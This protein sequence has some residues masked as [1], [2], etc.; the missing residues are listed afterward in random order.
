MHPS[1]YLMR[2]SQRTWAPDGPGVGGSDAGAGAS[3]S[4]GAANNS[5]GNS[6]GQNN[7]AA[8]QDNAGT[9]FDPATF[10]NEP[11][12]AGSGSPSGGSADSN[13]AG[14]SQ[15]Q[16]TEAQ[17]YGQEF[18]QRLSGLDFGSAFTPEIAS[19]VAEGKFEGINKAIGD[20]LKSATQNSVIMAAQ[21][22]Q[23]NNESLLSQVRNLIQESLGNRDNNATLAESF[24]ILAKDP[25]LRPMV[26]GVFNQAL[27]LAN[28]DR[29]KAVASTQE[30]LKYM[31]KTG[32][33]DLGISTPPPN[34]G[35]MSTDNSRSLVEELLGR[36][37]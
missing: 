1:Q 5:G 4:S 35:D 27:K 36:K 10:W 15:G 6:G 2:M 16:Q 17:R 31:G 13:S 19:Q 8:T 11:K 14:G 24:P 12:P 9:G 34:P 32:A 7:P 29:I 20:Q 23:K 21:L 25:A 37:I 30:M 26:E 28:G 33:G 22:M 18:Q 3:D